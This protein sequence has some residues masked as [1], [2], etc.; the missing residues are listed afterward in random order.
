MLTVESSRYR[1]N[2]C[3]AWAILNGEK[4]SLCIHKM[5]GG[6]LDS[7]DIITRVICLSTIAPK[8]LKFGSGCPPN[9][10][11]FL[12]QLKSWKLIRLTFGNTIRFL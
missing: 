8:L 12:R 7:G 10:S 5:I 2:A 1:G 11:A 3:Q 4:I 9:T 6:E